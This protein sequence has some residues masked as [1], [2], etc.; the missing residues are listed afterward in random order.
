MNKRIVSIMLVLA[1]LACA[2][3]AFAAESKA[4]PSITVGQL[5]APVVSNTETAVKYDESFAIFV[6]P[7][8]EES[9]QAVVLQEI[10]A[11]VEAQAPVVTFFN[12]EVVATVAEMLPEETDLSTL[13]MDE[14][15]PLEVEGYVNE[16]GDVTAAFEFV[17]EYEDETVLIVLVGV[18]PNEGDPEA[19]I[20]WYPIEATVAEGKVYIAFTEEILAQMADREAVMTVL[21]AEENV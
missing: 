11:V 20:V 10:T 6:K 8:A 17:T 14:F 4:V 1:M 13:V 15:F 5:V 2:A 7:V 21:R 19:E 3:C 12:E 9:K 18:L 16:Y